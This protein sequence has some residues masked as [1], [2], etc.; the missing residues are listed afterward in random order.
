MNIIKMKCHYLGTSC[1]HFVRLYWYCSSYLNL[2]ICHFHFLGQDNLICLLLLYNQHKASL[3]SSKA[4]FAKEDTGCGCWVLFACTM[5]ARTYG[6]EDKSKFYCSIIIK[7]HI[8][9][10]ICRVKCTENPWVIASGKIPKTVM[11][12]LW[13]IASWSLA[14]LWMDL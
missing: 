12:P 14:S 1:K 11:L 3:V 2:F 9:H 5:P 8:W 6:R 4:I 10:W 7:S 13:T